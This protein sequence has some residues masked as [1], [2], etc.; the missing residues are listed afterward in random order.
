M[1]VTVGWAPEACFVRLRLP[2]EPVPHTVEGS[3]PHVCQILQ[4]PDLLACSE[5]TNWYEM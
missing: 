5:V 3:Q 1:T 2:T 4:G